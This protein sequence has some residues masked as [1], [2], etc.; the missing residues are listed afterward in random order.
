MSEPSNPW[1]PAQA[2]PN[3][4]FVLTIV[5][6][7]SFTWPTRQLVTLTSAAFFTELTPAIF[8][9]DP[10]FWTWRRLATEE[11]ISDR[12]A[13]V[14]SANVNGPLPLIVTGTNAITFLPC[15]TT[16]RPTTSSFDRCGAVACAPAVLRRATAAIAS[17]ACRPRPICPYNW[18]N[19]TRDTAVPTLWTMTSVRTWWAWR[20][21][22]GG[23]PR[24]SL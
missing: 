13:P 8:P 6:G 15:L 19:L 11:S 17:A 5:V 21:E 3:G 9:A 16:V 7:G 1:I 24:V 22:R 18:R 20:H 14:S 2:F 12:D 4:R 23:S 10:F